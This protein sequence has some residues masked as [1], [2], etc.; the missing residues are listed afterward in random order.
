MGICVTNVMTHATD[1][2]KLNGLEYLQNFEISC[3]K[4]CYC[5]EFCKISLREY[6]MC[7]S[8]ASAD[9]VNFIERLRVISIMF[10]YKY[11]QY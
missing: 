6:A 1:Y 7:D 4:C 2:H 5:C 8:Y 10:S 9:M 3:S 11:D